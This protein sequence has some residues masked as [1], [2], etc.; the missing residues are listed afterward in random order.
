[1]NINEI[2]EGWRNHLFPPLHLKEIIKDTSEYRLKIC[3]ECPEHSSNKVGYETSRFDEHCT[4]CKC[5][6]S[7]KTKCLSCRCPLI[8]P[9]WGPILTLEQ[10]TEMKYG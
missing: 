9:K 10:E 4:D 1:M 8:P 6:L 2:Y 5:T 3:K 7:A